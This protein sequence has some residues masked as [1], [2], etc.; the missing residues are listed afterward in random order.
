[1][2]FSSRFYLCL[3]GRNNHQSISANARYPFTIFCVGAVEIRQVNNIFAEQLKS[4]GKVRRNTGVE[5]ERQA[6]NSSLV[7]YSIASSTPFSDTRYQAAIRLIGS[8]ALCIP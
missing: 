4:G 7:S 3:I 6:A 8:P 1:M 5:K 2:S